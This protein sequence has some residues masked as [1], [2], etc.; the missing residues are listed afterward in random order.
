M[1]M[2]FF[3]FLLLSYAYV[4]HNVVELCGLAR[5]LTVP[6]YNYALYPF[7]FLRLYF[8]CQLLHSTR[9]TDFDLRFLRFYF[10]FIIYPIL[11]NT[12][13]FSYISYRE[14]GSRLCPVKNRRIETN[15]GK[16]VPTRNTKH[17]SS[18]SRTRAPKSQKPKKS[19]TY[20][21]HSILQLVTETSTVETER[22][23]YFEKII[24]Q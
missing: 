22:M 14:E 17:R 15:R 5:W 8:L 1:I 20:W 6:L 24:N 21:C 4:E 23:C 13:E 7:F 19:P 2:Y 3:L 10:F 18:R 12:D 9:T 16:F 11:I